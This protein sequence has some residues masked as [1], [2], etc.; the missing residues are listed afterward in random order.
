LHS[1]RVLIKRIMF[2]NGTLIHVSLGIT[3]QVSRVNVINDKNQK[4]GRCRRTILASSGC[5]DLNKELVEEETYFVC[6]QV[7]TQ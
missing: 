2:T 6:D 7:Q 1:I 5:G 4:M 3:D